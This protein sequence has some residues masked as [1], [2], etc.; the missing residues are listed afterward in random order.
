MDP[1]FRSDWRPFICIDELAGVEGEDFAAEVENHLSVVREFIEKALAAPIEESEY[2][3]AQAK[4]IAGSPDPSREVGD[5][6]HI[7]TTTTNPAGDTT[8]A[9]PP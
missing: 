8:S 9:T 6:T 7:A 3:G 5:V 4:S 1:H 2:V